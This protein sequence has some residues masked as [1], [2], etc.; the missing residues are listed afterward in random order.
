[1]MYTVSDESL[2]HGR[3]DDKENRD[4]F[5]NFQAVDV[6][7]ANGD[8]TERYD[9]GILGYAVD[10]GVHMNQ[11][12]V[13]AK[14]GPDAVR[15]K[16]GNLPL[17]KDISIADFGNV[18]TDEPYVEAVQ[19]EYAELISK[20]NDYAKF[21]LLIGG[22]HDIAYAHFKGLKALYPDQTIGVVNI[23]AHFDLRDAQYAT[24]G[25]GFKQILDEDA[26][27]GYLVLG[28]QEVGN[29]QYLFNVAEQYDVKYV[30]AEDTDYDTTDEIIQS[31]IEQY[32]VIMLTLCLDVLDSAFAP[33]VSAPC[34]FGLTPQQVERLIRE[35]LSYGKTRHL[36]IAEMNPEYDIDGRTAKLVG[37]ISFHAVHRN[38][39]IL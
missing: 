27:A 28:L 39:N 36:S 4:H 37:H 19:K 5:R 6:I 26:D 9:V 38:P 14:H 8:L 7:D 30:L 11:G 16:F 25:T 24:S 2:W 13:G 12:R 17:M 10:R 3:I 35:V 18:S 1:M 15:T 29:T 21:H 23:D 22:G 31:F 34:S 33:G 20:T 32:D